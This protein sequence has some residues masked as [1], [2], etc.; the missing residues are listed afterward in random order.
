MC[1]PLSMNLGIF[2][3][4]FLLRLSEAWTL[5]ERSEALLPWPQKS[6]ATPTL[7]AMVVPSLATSASKR[8]L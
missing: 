8:I 1:L 2:F 5:E 3:S 7:T 6:S 4:E